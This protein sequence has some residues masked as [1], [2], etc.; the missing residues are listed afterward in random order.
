[1]SIAKGFWGHFSNFMCVYLLYCRCV[2]FFSHKSTLQHRVRLIHINTQ[3]LFFVV[4]MKGY[5]KN[6]CTREIAIIYYIFES[7]GKNLLIIAKKNCILSKKKNQF[8]ILNFVSLSPPLFGMVWALCRVSAEFFTNSHTQKFTVYN[9]ILHLS[10]HLR[11]YTQLGILP[12]WFC[13]FSV[14]LNVDDIKIQKENKSHT[15]T[16]T[17]TTHSRRE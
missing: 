12:L 7:R 14:N 2:Y 1:M 10:P 5:N 15:H 13:V 6:Y 4:K 3:S 17:R 9:C 11:I 16:H 8:A